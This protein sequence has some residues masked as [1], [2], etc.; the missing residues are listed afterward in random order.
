MRLHVEGGGGAGAVGQDATCL[1]GGNGGAG[2]ASTVLGSTVAAGGGG[3]LRPFSRAITSAVQGF[4]GTGGG[5]N[6]AYTDGAAVGASGGATNGTYGTGSG[7][8]AGYAMNG[9]SGIGGSGG[10]GIVALR[11]ITALVPTYTKPINA[12]LNVGMTETFT[13]N[14]A[15]DSATVGL[16]RTFKWESTTPTS[17]GSYT[18]LKVGTGASNAAYS[19]IPSDTSTTGSGYLY[20]LTVT[21]SD[22]AGLFITDSSTAYALINPTLKMTGSVTNIK[23]TINIARNETFTILDGTPGYR[24]TLSPVIA[25]ITI[26]TS[27]VGTTILR[28][29]DTAAVGTFLET[30]TV[31]DSVSA[32]VVIPLSITISAPPILTYSGEVISTGQVFNFDSSVSASYNSQTGA[33]AD[34]SGSQK[35]IT[36]NGGATYSSDFSGI[37]GLSTSQ[38]L[39]VTGIQQ[40]ASF[41]IEA[42]IKLNSITNRACVF[43]SE[44]TGYQLCIDSGRTVYGGFY[45]GSQWTYKRTS[46]TVDLDKWTHLL[47]TFDSSTSGTKMELYFNGS[48]STLSD[49][50]QNAGLVT[51][52]PGTNRSYINHDYPTNNALAASMSIGFVRLY[53]RSFG[54]ADVTQNYGATK[55]RFDTSNQSQLKPSKKYGVLVLDSFTATSGSGTRTITFA[56]GNRSGIMWDT[57]TVANQIQLSIQESLSAGT[58]F[59]TM[60]VTDN[61]GQSTYLPITF[62]VTKADTITVTSGPSL[63]TVYSTTAPTN[64]P[65][66]RV[67]GLVGVDTA[68]VTTSYTSAPGSTCATGGSCAI[69]D[70]GP[71]GGYVFYISGTAIDSATGISDG[72][73]YL[74]VAPKGWS[75]PGSE[76]QGQW[77]AAATSVSGT[78][79]SLG[80]GAE[81]TRKIIAALPST[82][83]LAKVTADLTYGGKS[84]W[85][86]PSSDEVKAMY[87]NLYAAS[88]GDFSPSNYWASTQDDLN[89]MTSRADT[90][91]FGAGNTYSPTDKANSYYLRPIRAFTPG[92]LTVTST[93]T[94]VDTYTVTGTNLTFGVGAASN[95]QAVVYETST[96]KITQANQNK[97]I[98]NLYGAVAGSPFTLV[99]TGGSGDGAVTETVTVG[100][101]ASNC[102]VSNHVLS[103]SNSS[104]QQFYCNVLVTKASS[105]NYK[106][107]SL[108]A[109][110]YFMVFLNSQP[111]GQVG[112]GSTIALNGMTS[113][114]VD[115]TTPPSITSLS[116]TLLSLGSGGIFTING[117]GFG[118]SGLT[119]KF[120]RNKIVTP[121][122]STTT[123]ITFNVSD[124]GSAGASTGRITVITVNGQD[125]STDTLTITP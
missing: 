103:N 31:T 41:T 93:P 63:T 72:G 70:I 8:G 54:L 62:T 114:S 50:G 90:Y 15:V 2:K 36:V 77:A 121:S 107:E 119:V 84:D 86:F 74:E 14:V 116:T 52:T 81:N 29:S 49:S 115:T 56:T 101:T 80:Q 26:D 37:L 16:T 5:G 7:G 47:V 117:T 9:Y 118:A 42:F 21:D 71:G 96:L 38:Y 102:S 68:T 99:T 30:L 98:L 22:T 64:G 69:G 97:L 40:M 6:S 20:R 3:S 23:K 110:V 55:S 59:D 95:Y 123:T 105:R 122:G 44:N 111:S 13:T 53:N 87:T 66:A 57:T 45:D 67:T 75:T 32:S 108:T 109:S 89:S 46:Q 35:P 79:R 12:Y 88:K 106:S 91:W 39:S 61:L 1:K 78:S 48:V 27:T 100:S 28:I 19:W 24:Y 120:W 113:Y 85:F 51:T 83:N 10:T 82:T 125:F 58:Y 25:G 104:S 18:T 76:Y 17:N 124:I 43:T 112:S 11:Y 34:I 94:D 60:T 65:V 33:V 4:G 92:A 73:T